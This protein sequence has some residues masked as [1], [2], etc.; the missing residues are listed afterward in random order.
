MLSLR[1]Q[2][3]IV[4]IIHSHNSKQPEQDRLAEDQP[5]AGLSSL[6]QYENVMRKSETEL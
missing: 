4:T 5:T 6:N 3:F 1:S 2:I